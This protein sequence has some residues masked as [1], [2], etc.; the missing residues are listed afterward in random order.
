MLNFYTKTYKY[1]NM[2]NYNT[3]IELID[4][5]MTIEI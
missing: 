1:V 2:F 3:K 4:D 5:N